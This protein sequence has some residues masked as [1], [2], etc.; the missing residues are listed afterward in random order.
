M[1]A[2]PTKI[3]QSGLPAMKSVAAGGSMNTIS[4][5]SWMPSTKA[6]RLWSMADER[7]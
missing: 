2:D 1:N 4:T 3:C 6:M 5:S 7:R